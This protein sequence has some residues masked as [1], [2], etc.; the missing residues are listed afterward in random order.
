MRWELSSSQR[1]TAPVG[2][3]KQTPISLLALT[4]LP[5]EQKEQAY[6]GSGAGD[7]RWLRRP[8]LWFFVQRGKFHSEMLLLGFGSWRQNLPAFS[9]GRRELY[10]GTIGSPPFGSLG[11]CIEGRRMHGCAK[12]GVQSEEHAGYA[13]SSEATPVN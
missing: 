6:G 7:H 3:A 13:V 4:H 5:N 2:K 12:K 1:L 11:R 9:G 8:S 10:F